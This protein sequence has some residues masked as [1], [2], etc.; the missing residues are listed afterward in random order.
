MVSPSRT[1]SWMGGGNGSRNCHGDLAEADGRVSVA[2]RRCDLLLVRGGEC[3]APEPADRCSSHGSTK[4]LERQRAPR[5]DIS[6]RLRRQRTPN[7]T[8]VERF[9]YGAVGA[10]GLT[11]RRRSSFGSIS[12]LMSL[13]STSDAPAWICNPIGPLRRRVASSS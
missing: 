8:V 4:C 12:I 6:V 11:V 10:A 5:R 2:H 9:G 7:R 1:V 3:A 13:Y